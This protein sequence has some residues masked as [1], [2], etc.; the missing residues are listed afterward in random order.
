MCDCYGHG[1]YWQINGNY[2]VLMDFV[3]NSHSIINAA[4][5][6]KIPANAENC[7]FDPINGKAVTNTFVPLPAEVVEKIEMAFVMNFPDKESIAQWIRQNYAKNEDKKNW[8]ERLLLMLSDKGKGLF[9][10]KGYTRQAQDCTQR[11]QYYTRQAQDYTQRAQGYTQRAQYCTRQ[12][13]DYTQL[14]Q[15]YTRQVQDYTQRAQYCTR[16]AQ[17]CTGELDE[18]DL[19]K[20]LDYFTEH[21]NEYWSE[22]NIPTEEIKPMKEYVVV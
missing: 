3:H 8:D 17:D 14:A 16:R 15:D 18:M 1:K 19:E 5:A 11:A 22:K 4:H 10:R 7:G 9:S 12:A 21:P 13:Q 6:D 20:F 2:V